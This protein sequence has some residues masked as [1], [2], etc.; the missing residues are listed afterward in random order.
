[1]DALPGQTL[2]P[3]ELATREVCLEGRVYCSPMKRSGPLAR[4]VD[5]RANSHR[6][7]ASA[8]V[9]TSMFVVRL[10]RTELVRRPESELSVSHLPGLVYLEATPGCSLSQIARYLGL[11]MPTA[12]KLIAAWTR[13]GLVRQEIPP[14]DRRKRALYLT[15]EGSACVR[16]TL[17]VLRDALAHRLFKVPSSQRALILRAMRLLRPHVS[18]LDV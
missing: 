3:S 11:G 18:P 16:R 6:R 4:K 7:C 12:S 10:L 17:N 9:D 14:G 13:R 2:A 8:V 5:P 15:R 1:M